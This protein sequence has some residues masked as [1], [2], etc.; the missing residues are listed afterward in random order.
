MRPHKIFC[1]VSFLLSPSISLHADS[2]PFGPAS[3]YNLVA[4]G[5]V[6]SGGNTVIA[7]N[8]TDNSDITGR[9]AAA[10]IISGNMTVGSGLNG[11]PYGSSAPYGLVATNGL[12]TGTHINM[13]GGGNAFA[14]GALTSNFNFNDGGTLT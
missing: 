6:D 10:N 4:L 7:G 5:T 3:A 8:I 1:L 11:D 14:P 13:N 12:G 9:I 2:L